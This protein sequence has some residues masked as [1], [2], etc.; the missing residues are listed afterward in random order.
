M[1]KYLL[2]SLEVRD[3]LIFYDIKLEHFF[4]DVFLQEPGQDLAAD[5]SE[6]M[7]GYL[8]GF[9]WVEPILLKCVAH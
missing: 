1:K 6:Q 9:L 5:A 8:F 3:M 2:Y 7:V 4:E